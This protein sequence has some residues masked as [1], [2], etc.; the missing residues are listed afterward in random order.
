VA[1]TKSL[2]GPLM[3]QVNNLVDLSSTAMARRGLLITSSLALAG[4]GVG[5]ACIPA[6][7]VAGMEIAPVVSCVLFTSG[8]L[9]TLLC[10]PKVALQ[11]VATVSTIYFALD[12]ASGLMIAICGSGEHLNLFVYLVWFFPL[13]VFNKLVNQPAVGRLLAR[14]LLAT[15]LIAIGLLSSRLTAVLKTPQLVLLIV[16]CLSYVCYAA[17]LNVVTRYREAYVVERARGE[18]RRNLEQ[19]HKSIRQQAELLDKAQDAIF[20]QDMDTRILYWNRSAERLYGR[21]AEE[22]IGRQVKEVF[23][24]SIK[25]LDERVASV[26]QNGEW[27]GIISQRHRDGSTLIVESRC[28]SVNEADGTPRSILSINTDITN[29][30]AAEARIE[31]LAFFDVLT[32]LPNRTLLQER[33]AK[34]L[35][36]AVHRGNMGALFFID[37]DDFKTLNDTMGHDTG[38]VLLQQV[39]QRLSPCLRQSDTV[40][41]LGGDEFVVM[42]EGLGAE[43]ELAVAEAR[44]VGDKVLGAFLQPYN[45]GNCEYATTASIGIALFP[46]WSDSVDEVLK[47]ADLAMHQAKAQ[48]RSKMRFFD[49]AMQTSVVSRAELQ[50]DLSRALRNKEFELHYQPQV[51]SVGLVIG[52][53]ALLRWKHPR[54]GMVPPSEFIPFVEESGHILELGRW[55]LHTACFQLAEWATRP[56][57]ERLILAV[58]VSIRQF[59]D[60]NFVGLVLDVIRESGVNPQR[61]K[62]EITESAMVEN[63]EDTIAK[64]TALKASGIGFSLDD[65]GTGHSSLSRLKRLPLD[66][67]KV[68]GSFV[69]GVL[70]DY[71]DASIVRTIIMLGQNLNLSVIAEGVETEGQRKFLENEGCR[72]YQG[73]LFSPA[74]TA[75]RFEDFVAA[76]TKV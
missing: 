70:T 67:L 64:M 50:S 49:P 48:G 33:L 12:L 15:P 45:V 74:L 59:M 6:G 54:R 73:Y 60:P 47:R 37:L 31:H 46:T 52:A 51:G 8:V 19:A 58:N 24:D 2:H 13:L 9:V 39:A 18:S 38:D 21:R 65:F 42:V 55:V 14:I 41:R 10:F 69:K 22:V 20:V 25:E 17:M 32:E 29:R 40:A 11:T 66:Q 4:A 44:A 57:M 7:M 26:L 43:E 71:R 61:L 68:D 75:A 36:T 3:H 23:S 16:Y 56:E 63:T 35:A 72:A 30:K 1:E 34:A 76:E 5:V 28:A 27:S 62:I 53:E